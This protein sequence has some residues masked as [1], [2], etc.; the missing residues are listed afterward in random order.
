VQA[1]APPT[2]LA[3]APDGVDYQEPEK[4]GRHDSFL[5]DLMQWLGQF[6]DLAKLVR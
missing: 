2:Q 5:L 1:D 3:P 6:L 4:L